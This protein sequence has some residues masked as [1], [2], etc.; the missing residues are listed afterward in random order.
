MGNIICKIFGHQYYNN[1]HDV[2]SVKM[3][4]YKPELHCFRCGHEMESLSELF[5]KAS[6]ETRRIMGESLRKIMKDLEFDVP[7]ET[8]DPKVIDRILVLSKELLDLME[9][10][11]GAPPP[12]S[13]LSTGYIGPDKFTS[14]TTD[15]ETNLLRAR[16]IIRHSPEKAKNE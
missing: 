1:N 13:Y 4:D 5:S 14:D 7:E 15:I 3:I 2:Y 16:A 10:K 8:H 12:L 9:E 6:P 11:L